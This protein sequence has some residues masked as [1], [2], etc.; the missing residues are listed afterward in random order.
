M[1]IP[2]TVTAELTSLQAQVKAAG[3]LNSA[4]RAT[5]QAIKLNSAQLVS[6][7]QAALVAPNNL[8]DTWI[9]PVDPADIISGVLQVAEAGN[10]QNALALM[11]GV[12]GRA[13]SNLDQV[14]S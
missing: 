13:N 10:D 12:V 1:T 6:D 8:L 7:V 5:V 11:R 2:A 4:P 9:A 3:A 14:S